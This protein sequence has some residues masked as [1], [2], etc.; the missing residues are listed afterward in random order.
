MT[1]PL[2]DP[3]DERMQEAVRICT[4]CHNS[5]MR[6]IAYCMDMGG[7]HVDAPHLRSLLDC[8]EACAS[9]VHFMLRGSGLHPQVCG[10]CADACLA[11]AMSCEQFPSDERMQA[12]AE[13]CR[14]CAES[15]REMAGVR[16]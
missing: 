3:L 2:N 1:L 10:V 5:C 11:C 12:C 4:E 8:A 9:S 13:T 15:C 16:V 6:T 14:R 7:M